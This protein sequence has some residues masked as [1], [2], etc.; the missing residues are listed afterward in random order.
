MTNVEN[1]NPKRKSK[2]AKKDKRKTL[3]E[4]KGKKL[5]RGAKVVLMWC[6][7]AY[8]VGQTWGFNK[9]VLQCRH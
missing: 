8:V 9:Y 1:E 3:S 7:G 5:A 6:C 2:W 4:K